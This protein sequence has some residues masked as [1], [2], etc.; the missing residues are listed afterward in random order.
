MRIKRS[1]LQS[2]NKLISIVSRKLHIGLCSCFAIFTAP[3]LSGN[4]FGTRSIVAKLAIVVLPHVWSPA[5]DWSSAFYADNLPD[6][7]NRDFLEIGC[8]HGCAINRSG[9]CRRG[10]RPC[11]R[12]KRS[13]GCQYASQL[14]APQPQKCG[15]YHLRSAPSKVASLPPSGPAP[16][17][18]VPGPRIL[19]QRACNT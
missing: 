11:R 5:Y 12:H 4:S 13:G 16:N 1:T 2:R 17:T 8:G 14:P 3:R 19:T 15:S 7:Q 18:I 6:L 10:A 9:V